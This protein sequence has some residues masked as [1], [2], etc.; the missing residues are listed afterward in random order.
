MITEGQGG[1]LEKEGPCPWL[2]HRPG[3]SLLLQACHRLT[4]S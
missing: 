3:Y 1:G 4:P 2:W